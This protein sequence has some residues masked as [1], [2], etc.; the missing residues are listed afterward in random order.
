M[1]KYISVLQ[2]IEEHTVR[3]PSARFD[4]KP[5]I[6]GRAVEYPERIEEAGLSC[7]PVP[8]GDKTVARAQVHKDPAGSSAER[9]CGV[10]PNA[11][12]LRDT[13]VLS[14]SYEFRV[15]TMGMPPDTYV[16]YFCGVSPGRDSSFDIPVDP[17]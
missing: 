13:P 5:G 9:G 4:G 14:L 16:C 15:V 3:P 11:A 1:G 7:P 2:E 17:W 10:G 6:K 12:N 8:V